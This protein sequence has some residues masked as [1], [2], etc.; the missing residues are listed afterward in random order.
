MHQFWLDRGI[1]PAAAL[2]ITE[3]SLLDVIEDSC[4]K[5][6]PKTAFSN[7]GHDMSYGQ[8]DQLSR[9]FAAYL[10]S[11]PMLHPGDR[12]ALMAPN[13]LG[14][15]VAC[16]GIIRGGFVVVNTNPLYT[17]REMQ[18]QFSDSGA[19]VLVIFASM[20]HKAEA[21]IAQTQIE[22]V[23]VLGLADLHPTLP[24]CFYHFMFK[25]VAKMEKAYQLPQAISFRQALKQGARHS[26]SRPGLHQDAIA[27]LQ[28][29]GGTT[30]VAKGAMLTHGNLLANLAQARVIL[31]N[32][33]KDAQEVVIVPLPLYHIYSFTVSMMGMLVTGNQSILITN[34]RDTKRFVKT[35]KRY[36]FTGIVGINTLFTALCDDADF[37]QLDFSRLHLTSSGGMSLTPHIAKVWHEVTGCEILEGYGLTEAS[38]I[39][40]FNLEGHAKLGSIGKPVDGTDLKIVDD[41]EHDLPLGDPE[42]RGELWVKGPQV[43]LGYWQRPEE[44]QK[45]ITADGWL[46]TGDMATI[47]GEGYVRIVDRKK[48]MIIVSGFNVYPNEI[49]DVISKHP[50][51]LEC[52]AVGVPNSKTGEAIKLFV[53]K[54]QEQLTSEELIS[55]TRTQLTG[56]KVP[57][58]VEFR[59]ELPKS[60]V[61]KILRK[62][63]RDQC[64]K[65]EKP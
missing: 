44:T 46:R 9:D 30:G 13:I 28:Y 55:Y 24:R 41:D 20:A 1:K 10:Q 37:R 31:Q 53:V 26:Y 8:L 32:H 52:A 51:V 34:P 35:L 27:M 65:G 29:T 5:F 39:V 6:A 48:D 17:E 47:D 3:D 14:Y 18:H 16:L 50:G 4:Q 43:M 33:L 59:A 38:P 58:L 40:S 23:V 21:I 12:V 42:V 62:D 11:L 36:P 64:L 2:P 61:G 49:E 19:K 60:P 15:P 54:K 7:I 22:K 45:T 25:Y 63:L 57:K 56:Y